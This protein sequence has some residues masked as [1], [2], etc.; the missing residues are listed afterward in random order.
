MSRAIKLMLNTIDACAI[1]IIDLTFYIEWCCS[2]AEK[3]VGSG[4]GEVI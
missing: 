1:V 3:N 4:Q 2:E